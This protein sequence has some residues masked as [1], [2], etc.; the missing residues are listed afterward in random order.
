MKCPACGGE[1][2]MAFG[3]NRTTGK[4]D[5]REECPHTCMVRSD[6]G[7]YELCLCCA[8]CMRERAICNAPTPTLRPRA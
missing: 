6:A 7:D 8:E 2:M 5:V 3:L 4:Y 1:P